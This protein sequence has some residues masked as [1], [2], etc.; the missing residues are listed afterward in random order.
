MLVNLRRELNEITRCIG[1]GKAG[2]ALM[3]KQTVQRVTKFMEQGDD[4]IP[5]S[6]AVCPAAGF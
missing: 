4:I 3:G 5:E 2:V 1:P 6:S